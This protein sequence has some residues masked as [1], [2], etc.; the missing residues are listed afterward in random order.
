[1]SENWASAATDLAAFVQYGVDVWFEEHNGYTYGASSINKG[2]VGH[3]TEVCFVTSYS[4]IQ[5]LDSHM[6]GTKKSKL[7]Q[8]RFVEK[9]RKLVVGF[10]SAMVPVIF[11]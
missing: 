3:Y 2:L 6:L 11:S 10:H 9:S 4:E 1:M 5:K 7:F 8:R